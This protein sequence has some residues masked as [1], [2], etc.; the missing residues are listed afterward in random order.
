MQNNTRTPVDTQCD[1][2]L[3][4]P[5]P[6]K[7]EEP[8]KFPGLEHAMV[9]QPDYGRDTYKGSERLKGKVAL[10]TGGDSGIGRAVA[11]AFAREGASVMITYLPEEEEDARQILADI[12]ESGAKG[13]GIPGDLSSESFCSELMERTKDAFGG[14]DI[15]VNNAALQKHFKGFEDIGGNDFAGI[16]R[17]NVIA[18]FLLSKAAAKYMQPGSSIINTVS[19][20]AYAPSSYLLPYA[21]SKGAFVALTK[22]LAEELLAHGI[23]VN[24]V[25]PGPIWSPLNTHGSSAEKLKSFGEHSGFK[26][27]G[28]PVELSPVYVFLASNDASYVNGEIYGVTGGDRI[29]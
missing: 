20:Q 16:Y 10:I 19:I 27:P 17:V 25:A 22:G 8:Q 24:A 5:K 14:I 18:P 15:L 28:Q 13:M 6:G 11:L 29:A 12:E 9:T 26:R 2:R 3:K 23:R 4:F 1:P 7:D 21:A